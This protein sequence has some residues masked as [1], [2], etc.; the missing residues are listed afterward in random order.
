M[1][2]VTLR[3]NGYAYTIGCKDGEEQHLLAMGA[4]LEKRIE[5]IKLRAGQ[6]GESRM[7]VM[8]GLLMADE[9]FDL[10]QRVADAESRAP[11]E[12]NTRLNRRLNRVAKRAEEIAADLERP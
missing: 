1:A 3:I 9:L 8:A 5:S 4:E 12:G 2:Q 6:S 7:L 11:G 10:R